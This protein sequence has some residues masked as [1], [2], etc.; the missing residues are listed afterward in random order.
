MFKA[1][2]ILCIF[3]IIGICICA[4]IFGDLAANADQSVEE[5]KILFANICSTS[6]S[7]YSGA[8]DQ[9][10]N[11]QILETASYLT[12]LSSIFIVSLY[13]ILAK[14]CG[15]DRKKLVMIFPML[16][17]VVLFGVA[18][19]VAVQG[20]IVTYGAYILEVW[21]I[22]RVHYFLIGGIGL[23]A[24]VATFAVF[25]AV[26]KMYKKASHFQI[27]K[28]VGEQDDPALWAFVR[29]IADEIKAVSPD[30]IIVGIEPTFYVTA[31]EV[32]GSSDVPLTGETLYLSLTLLRLL[33]KSELKAIVAHELGHFKGEDTSYSLKFAPVHR[34]LANS[35]RGLSGNGEESA[36]QIAALPALAVLQ[37][38]Y[39]SFDLSIAKVNRAREFEADNV[40]VSATSAEDFSY[41]LTKVSMFSFV[42][43]N[44]I[45]HN[46]E[47]LS[48]RK[49]DDN[50]SKVF[51]EEIAYTFSLDQVKLISE[52]V[53]GNK[54]SH[55]TDSHPNL[56]DRLDNAWFDKSKLDLSKL[57]KFSRCID[58]LVPNFEVIEEELTWLNNSL[59]VQLG[60]VTIPDEVQNSPFADLLYLLGAA[61]VGADGKIERDEMA[62]AQTAGRNLTNDFDKVDFRIYCENL[63]EIPDL[64]SA[65]ESLRDIDGEIKETLYDYLK[66]IAEADGEVAEEELRLLDKVANTWQLSTKLG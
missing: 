24:V 32:R 65:V 11:I 56:A 64:E 7:E 41:A 5:L 53:L 40:A 18:I 52:N 38:M 28:V 25:S 3:P 55:P 47:R 2:G 36:T 37:S 50:L 62:L 6:Y 12:L 60:Q 42:W 1:I 27:G 34:G 15:T 8:C 29:S 4:Y 16:V 13:W 9:I 21:L 10:S 22:E 48:K 46:I 17:P 66:A 31:A 54:I 39:E 19:Q 33:D 26:F 61:M 35:I 43:A 59:A 14:F 63:K 20:A 58:E 30:N 49:V 23:G 44:V 51:E 45:K 57:I